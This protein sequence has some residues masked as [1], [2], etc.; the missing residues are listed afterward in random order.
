MKKTNQSR[1]FGEGKVVSR[2]KVIKVILDGEQAIGMSLL[3]TVQC[4]HDSCA[5]GQRYPFPYY[6]RLFVLL[7]RRRKTQQNSRKIILP[8]H[9]SQ[10][11]R[12]AWISKFSISSPSSNIH[13]VNCISRFFSPGTIMTRKLKQDKHHQHRRDCPLIR[14]V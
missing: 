6:D 10:V 2:E 8:I 7:T 9:L 3:S 14:N 4:T 1:L 13:H 12:I 11:T 5:P